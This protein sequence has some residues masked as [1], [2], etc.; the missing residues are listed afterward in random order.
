MVLITDTSRRVEEGRECDPEQADEECR[1]EYVAVTRAKESL[2]I[3]ES[4]SANSMC[5]PR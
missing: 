4:E 1:L 3:C 2:V 5:I